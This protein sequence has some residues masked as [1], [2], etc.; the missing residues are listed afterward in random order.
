MSTRKRYPQAFKEEA[1]RLSY[2][3]GKTVAQQAVDLGIQ[4]GQLY[5]W[6]REAREHGQQAFPG[7]GTARDAELA[8]WK[9]RA[10]RAEQE[11]EVLKKVLT[12]FTPSPK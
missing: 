4:E 11:R 7:N 12:I 2:T 3:S 5:S 6:R 10:L 8:E 9:R 1:V